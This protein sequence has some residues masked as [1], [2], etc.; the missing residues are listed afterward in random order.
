M[1]RILITGGAGFI[2]SHVVRL[3]VTT[4]DSP[5]RVLDDFST[6]RRE[7]LAGLEKGV[8]VVEGDVRDE[9]A[10]SE[11]MDGADA[12]IHLAAVASVPESIAD[13]ATTNAVNVGGTLNLL[14][15]ARKAGVRRFVFA[16]STAVYGEREKL[17]VSEEDPKEPLSPY[18]ASKLIGEI[19]G[20]AYHRLHGLPFTALRYFN[21]FG[22][23]QDENSPYAAVIPLFLGRIERGEA[24]VIFGDGKQSRDFIHVSDVA[25]ANRLAL[26]RD[27]A[28]G[29]VFNIGRG[30][31]IDLNRLAA[32]IGRA[33]GREIPPRRE[34][35]RPGDIIRSR[36]NIERARRELGFEPRT[37]LEEGLRETLAWYRREV[38]GRGKEALRDRP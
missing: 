30:E 36:A 2:G 35:P 1:G 26:E 38:A 29:R 27:E 31:A 9:R 13:P 15:G 21:V 24:P 3:L 4:G 8:E 12:V 19:Y 18:A 34:A 33:A 10:V 20:F 17:P 37:G 23:R 16:S 5:L 32:L 6:G 14:E 7:N 22:S 28:V 25:E 11:A